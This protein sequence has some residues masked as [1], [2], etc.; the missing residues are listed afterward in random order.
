MTDTVLITGGNRGIGLAT[1]CKLVGQGHHVIITA[2]NLQQGQEA[3][4]AIRRQVVNANV[5]AMP[6]DLASFDATRSF[7]STSTLQAIGS[8]FLSIMRV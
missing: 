5:V 2:R 8:V 4:A 1:A 6:L 7:S 3:I